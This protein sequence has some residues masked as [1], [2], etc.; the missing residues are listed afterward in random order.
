MTCLLRLGQ[1]SWFPFHVLF[2]LF[3]CYHTNFHNLYEATDFPLSSK[4]RLLT[5][6]KKKALW[7]LPLCFWARRLF[8][9]HLE[10]GGHIQ[11]ALLWQGFRNPSSVRTRPS[12]ESL[13]ACYTVAD[14]YQF[15]FTYLC[16]LVS[17]I[18]RYASMKFAEGGK[19]IPQPSSLTK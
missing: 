11:V 14:G 13:V 19:D 17:S 15:P 18:W 3:P 12:V 16:S 4:S 10:K 1:N 9:Y 6:K 2:L 5:K 7:N 8:S